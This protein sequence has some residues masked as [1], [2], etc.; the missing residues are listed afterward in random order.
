MSSRQTYV[1]FVNDDVPEGSNSRVA[2]ALLGFSSVVSSSSREFDA[3][4][5]IDVRVGRLAK[6]MAGSRSWRHPERRRSDWRAPEGGGVVVA[7]NTGD[8]NF[9][10][11]YL[12]R[13]TADWIA[14][15]DLGN[16]REILRALTGRPRALNP[17]LARTDADAMAETLDAMLDAKEDARGRW[18]EDARENWESEIDKKDGSTSARRRVSRERREGIRPKGEHARPAASFFSGR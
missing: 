17:E 11:R 9:T 4:P 15:E 10:A 1:V 3:T 14:E 18:R 5:F 8:R 13:A 2:T 12:D 6:K 7:T 16:R